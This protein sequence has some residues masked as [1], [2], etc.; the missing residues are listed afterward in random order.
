MGRVLVVEDNNYSA[1]IILKIIKNVDNMLDVIRV[2]NASR[3]YE[4]ALEYKIDLFIIDIVLEPK[5][6][7]DVSG[8]TFAR[9]IRKMIQYKLTPIIF[10]SS[11]QVSKIEIYQTIHCYSFV[12]KPICDT[13]LREL[14]ENVLKENVCNSG[15]ECIDFRINGIIYPVS[16]DEIVYVEYVKGILCV[17]T[18]KEIIKVPYYSL[19]ELERKTDGIFWRCSKT[20]LVNRQYVYS[21]DFVNRYVKLIDG[22][23]KLEIGNVMKKSI[24]KKL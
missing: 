4:M 8:L 10:V 6:A 16:I 3:A 17:H 11:K 15:K 14:V 19:R 18:K 7:R 13:E 12:E 24:K 2:N 20:H 9:N 5:V 23:G 22:Y 1:D 21:W